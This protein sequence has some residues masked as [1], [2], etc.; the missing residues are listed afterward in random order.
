MKILASVCALLLLATSAVAQSPSEQEHP[1][2]LVSLAKEFRSWKGA[3]SGEVP[4][5]VERVQEQRRGLKDFKKRLKALSPRGWSVHAQVDYLVL[6]IE[7]NSLDYN[8]NVVQQVSRNPDF[9]TMAAVN[10]VARH[11][12]RR[13]Q[14]GPRVT[15]PYDA[16]R[17]EAIVEALEGTPAIVGQ[18]RNA[19]TQGVPEMADM[20]VEKLENV[21]ENY[22]E[23]ARVVGPHLPGPYQSQIGPAAEKA[24]AALEDYRN[25]IQANRSDM[26]AP[27]AVGQ[28]A[29]DWHV[30]NVLAMPYDS[31]DIL[32]QAEMERLRNWAFLQ[33]ERQMNTRLPRYGGFDTPPARPAKSNEEYAEWKDATDVLSR[34][35]AEENS[36]FTRPDYLGPMR[37][38]DGGVWI[39]PFGFMAFPTDSKPEGTKTEF[40]LAPDHWFS[41]AYWEVGHR[42]DPG[43]NHAHSDYPGHTFER[44]VSQKT[45]CEL[46]RGHNTRGDAWTYYMEE[47]QLQL[48]YPFVRGPRVREWMYSLAIMRAERLY[49]AVKMADGSMT[50]EQVGDYMMEAVPWMDPHVARK[51]EVWRKYVRPTSVLSYQVGKFEIYKLLR[52]EMMERGDD[53]DLRAFHDSLFATGQIP[54]SLAR[55]E[56]TGNDTDVR[57]LWES[58]PMPSIS[59]TSP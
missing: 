16:K 58:K 34:L 9:Y 54:I 31:G 29:F 1:P 41:K 21:R 11:V 35:W 7:M 27:Y 49:I 44:A 57:H 40:L 19:L 39:E 43:T 4:D 24:G 50:P 17:A 6:L 8:L 47:A 12:G 26:T 28:A 37:H 33:F 36:L 10:G 22:A 18:A 46:R 3:R 30:Q 23:F 53:F 52:D 51:H 2:E 38:E 42:L 13:Y 45:T 48:D 20:A 14:M 59:T 32:M 55:W 15:V 25:W 56:L 5:Y